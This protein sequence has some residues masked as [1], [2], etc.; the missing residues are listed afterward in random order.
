MEFISNKK[1]SFKIVFLLSVAALLWFGTFGLMYHMSEMKQD[2]QM[3]GCLFDGQS[4]ICTM[5][6]S[7]HLS[8]WQSAFTSLPTNT[9][10]LS[11]LALATFSLLIMAFWRDPLFEFYERAVYR[12]KLYI[13]HFSQIQ[14]FNS[15]REAFSQGILNPKIYSSII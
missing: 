5:N 3:S 12:W 2:A 11:L 10:L 4:E 8:S 9:V 14:I 6:F 7:E 15:L 1:T 13:K